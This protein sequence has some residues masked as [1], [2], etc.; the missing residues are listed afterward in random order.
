MLRN[1]KYEG[2]NKCVVL[3]RKIIYKK[4]E[5]KKVKFLKSFLAVILVANV[6]IQSAA[7]AASSPKIEKEQIEILNNS[8]I[9]VV[10]YEDSKERTIIETIDNENGIKSIAE[11]DKV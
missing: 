10:L 7:M 4:R 8:G 2:G 3:L 1:I 11:Y 9:N 5:R 6:L